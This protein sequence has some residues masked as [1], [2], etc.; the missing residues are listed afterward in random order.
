M[1]TWH[2][3]VVFA[4]MLIIKTHTCGCWLVIII[5]ERR[6]FRYGDLSIKCTSDIYDIYFQSSKLTF[7]GIGQCTNE[8]HCFCFSIKWFIWQ[9]LERR[10][11]RDK[12]SIQVRI[13]WIK[14]QNMF[15]KCLFKRLMKIIISGNQ[16]SIISGFLLAP[17]LTFIILIN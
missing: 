12:L 16:R 15:W 3:C 11:W 6:H 5:L 10:Q 2:W 14:I 4:W 9:S 8:W 13:H 1:L 7:T 17:V